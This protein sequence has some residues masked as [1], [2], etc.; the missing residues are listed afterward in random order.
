MGTI[1]HIP[2]EAK[3]KIPHVPQWTWKNQTRGAVGE[4]GA[5]RGRKEGSQ[6]RVQSSGYYGDCEVFDAGYP[7]LHDSFIKVTNLRHVDTSYV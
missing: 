1:P 7:V 3:A 5:V 6:W 2:L 4:G